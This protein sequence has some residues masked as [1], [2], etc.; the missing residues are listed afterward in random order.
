MMS[1][2]WKA[3]NRSMR[4][5]IE[6][7]TV[8][9]SRMAF[10]GIATVLVGTLVTPLAVGAEDQTYATISAPG[11]S[12]VG[13]SRAIIA[14]RALQS[15]DLGSMQEQ[16][17]AD[18]TAAAA[19]EDETTGSDTVEAARA[20]H[21]VQFQAGEWSLS[22]SL[23]LGGMQEQALAERLAHFRT[24]ELSLSRSLGAGHQETPAC[25]IVA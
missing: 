20:A 15:G 25:E 6:M 12:E 4:K 18:V 17:L 24:I 13:A 7:R 1:K 10:L 19:T 23:D 9:H 11:P 2:C 8:H 21:L 16:A 14:E 22:D 3:S 5:D